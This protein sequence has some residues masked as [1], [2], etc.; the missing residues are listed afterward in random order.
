VSERVCV[1]VCVFVCVHVCM[2]AGACA[3]ACV[4]CRGLSER[5]NETLHS[6]ELGL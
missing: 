5:T 6:V 1:Y 4:V 2:C 3:C